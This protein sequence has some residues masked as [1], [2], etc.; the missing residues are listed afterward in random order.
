[1]P[2]RCTISRP[3][4]A[5]D[6]FG[7]ASGTSVVAEDVPCYWWVASGVELRTGVGLVA[8]DRERLIVRRDTDIRVGDRITSLVDHRGASVF[9]ANDYRLVDHVAI[10]RTHVECSLR[11][12]QPA[13][14]RT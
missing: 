5:A 2:M 7:Q 10:Q 4:E 9:G 13:G 1:M 14:G 3:T 11:F 12:G 6:S 8:V